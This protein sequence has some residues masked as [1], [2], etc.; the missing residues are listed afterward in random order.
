[1]S[2]VKALPL[3]ADRFET[4][5]LFLPLYETVRDLFRTTAVIPTKSGK[6]VAD[7]SGSP[8]ISII[9]KD[10]EYLFPYTSIL[11]V[12]FERKERKRLEFVKEYH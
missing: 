7:L 12:E 4:V 5:G 10:N 3:S 2:F 1:M 8:F 6:Y 9:T 11:Y